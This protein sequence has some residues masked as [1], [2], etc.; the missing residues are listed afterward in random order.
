MAANSVSISLAGQTRRPRHAR[1][2]LG[3]I[4]LLQHLGSCNG[5]SQD[6][7]L[8]IVPSPSRVRSHEAERDCLDPM[9]QEAVAN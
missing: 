5:K 7:H 1:G 9:A 2:C 4:P 6:F 3:H 8:L